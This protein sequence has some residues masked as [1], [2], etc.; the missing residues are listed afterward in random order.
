MITFVF[1]RTFPAQTEKN[2]NESATTSLWNSI[3]D[4]DYAVKNSAEGKRKSIFKN[5]ERSIT[6]YVR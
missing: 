5:S 1:D 4:V 3:F 6:L 2:T